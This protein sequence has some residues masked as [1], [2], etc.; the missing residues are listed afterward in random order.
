MPMTHTEKVLAR[1]AGRQAVQ[2][3]DFLEIEPDIGLANDITAPLAIEEFERTGATRVKYPE[4]V[5]LVPDHFTPNK[6]IQSAEQVKT[7]ARV[8]AEARGGA[9]LR[10]GRGGHRARAAAR[11]GRHRAGHD[12]LR[13]GQPHLHL[14]R[15]GRLRHGRG[16]D[17]PRGLLP[18]G[19]GMAAGSPDDQ[20][21]FQGHGSRVGDGQGPDPRPDRKDLR[22]GS[23]L[24]GDRVHG[25]GHRR[26]VRRGTPDHGEHGHRGG[27]QE[28]HLR[29][30]R[31]GEG[32][33]ERPY[34]PAL[35]A[36]GR[37]PRRALRARGRDRRG[38]HGTGGGVPAPARAT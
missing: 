28:R 10:A 21:G 20:S 36:D 14:R 29:G 8:R 33:P 17:R 38:R 19:Q 2:P 16:I 11:D 15:P 7:P 23:H 26:A 25:T 22:F 9:V 34:G 24:P 30:R 3:G 31:E 1:A 4:R 6:D 32:V 18:D 27:R 37:R 13:R 5:F 35:G 12:D